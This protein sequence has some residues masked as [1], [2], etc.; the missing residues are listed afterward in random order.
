MNKELVPGQVI[1]R[2][3][4]AARLGVSVAPVLEAF[5]L[6]K[7]E[8]FVQT[9]S[10]KGTI[11]SPATDIQIYGSLIVREALEIEAASFYCGEKIR[12]NY[13]ELIAYAEEMDTKKV[14]SIEHARM[15]IILHSS[16]VNLAGFPNLFSVFTKNI[17]L[18]MFF[19]LNSIQNSERVSEHQHHKSFINALC[20]DDKVEAGEIVRNHV[21]SGKKWS[22]FGPDFK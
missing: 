3:E 21:R 18:G 8:G 4:I 17:R 5:V 7:Q 14:Y 22:L 20:T 2:R 16:L 15:E 9:L 11:V 6:L 10:R 1:N 13:D 19:R 12:Q